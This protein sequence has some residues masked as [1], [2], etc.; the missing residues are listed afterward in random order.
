MYVSPRS[1]QIWDAVQGTLE[2]SVNHASNDAIMCGAWHPDGTKFV[3]GGTHGQ[4]YLFVSIGFY[5]LPLMI[6]CT[7]PCTLYGS[8]GRKVE[9]RTSA[10][11]RFVQHPQEQLL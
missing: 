7:D 2:K 10:M 6:I 1:G 11:L 3:C 8:T 4:F 9:A 5:A